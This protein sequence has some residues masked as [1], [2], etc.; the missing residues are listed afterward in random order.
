[1]EDEFEVPV[2][3]PVKNKR[4]GHAQVRTAELGSD[5]RTKRAQLRSTMCSGF[6]LFFQERKMSGR[7]TG[8]GP[9]T[10]CQVS[11]ISL[12]SS[13]PPVASFDT[14]CKLCGR[15][16]ENPDEDS[17]VFRPS[18]RIAAE[19]FLEDTFFPLVCAR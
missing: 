4:G 13:F 2:V 9:V 12:R 11:I 18:K 16:I 5:P 1:M 19:I 6:C 15:N 8:W 3:E 17:D 7:F 10:H 14:I